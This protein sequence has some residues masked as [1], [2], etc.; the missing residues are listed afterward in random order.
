VIDGVLERDGGV[1]EGREDG[2]VERELDGGVNDG[3]E[4]VAGRTSGLVSGGRDV[5][6]MPW[7]E[8]KGE[9]GIAGRTSS[10]FLKVDP[11][12]GGR[13]S[14]V[15]DG[16][17]DEEEPLSETS[18]RWLLPVPGKGRASGRPKRERESDGVLPVRGVG[19]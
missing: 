7:R 6:G 5:C 13:P 10:A 15:A 3:R 14:A 16:L 1:K 12:M 8:P 19:D 2:P 9:V 4:G 11:G 18:G 17:R